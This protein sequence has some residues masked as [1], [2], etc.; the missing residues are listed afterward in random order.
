MKY[1]QSCD[2]LSSCLLKG[3]TIDLTKEETLW[4]LIR[5]LAMKI[6][7]FLLAHTSLVMFG[8]II[9]K[10]S[11][12]STEE[13]PTYIK[14]INRIITNTIEQSCIF[15][16]LFTYFLI[17][18]SGNLTFYLAEQL[19]PA[20]LMNLAAWFLAGR[21]LFSAGY[22]VGTAI[23]LP[24]LRSY[25]F[26]LTVLVQVILVEHIFCKSACVSKFLLSL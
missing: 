23:G 22:M 17:D 3:V 7:V 14:L 13:D 10:K 26:A 5:N 24:Q 4:A 16:G 2:C 20:L 18:G 15:L 8:R 19:S 1:T 12:P 25:G 9:F 21:I 11:S 6:A